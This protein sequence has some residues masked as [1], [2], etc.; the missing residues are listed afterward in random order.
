MCLCTGKFEINSVSARVFIQGVS[1]QFRH[2]QPSA[3]MGIRRT[4]LF[5]VIILPV[6]C[7]HLV[8]NQLQHFAVIEMMDRLVPVSPEISGT[9]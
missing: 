9:L 2:Y 8:S 7:L 5:E 1:S 6:P 4:I 3:A